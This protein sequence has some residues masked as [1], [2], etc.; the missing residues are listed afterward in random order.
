MFK[1]VRETIEICTNEGYH[2]LSFLIKDESNSFPSTSVI[3]SYVRD[4]ILFLKPTLT[5]DTFGEEFIT[6][7]HWDMWGGQPGDYCTSASFYGCDRS[8]GGGNVVNPITSARFRT[9]Q[10]F[11]MKYGKVEARAK[12]ARQSSNWFG[13]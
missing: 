8:G 1:F 4:G 13:D 12:V 2:H 9:A 5:S 6:N 3:F 11:T 10:S 7:G